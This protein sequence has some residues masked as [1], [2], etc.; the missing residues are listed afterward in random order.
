MEKLTD[1]EKVHYTLV[2][3]GMLR[4]SDAKFLYG[5]RGINLDY[6]AR[7]PLWKLGLDFN[8]GTGHGVGFLSLYVHERPNGFPA[9][10]SSRSARIAVSWRKAW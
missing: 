10:E 5:C 8:H 6:L 1:E 2:L 4:L 3:M 9:G 7:G